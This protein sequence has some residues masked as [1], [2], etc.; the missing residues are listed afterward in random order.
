MAQDLR[1]APTAARNS[2]KIRTRVRLCPACQRTYTYKV[3]PLGGRPPEY[4]DDTCKQWFTANQLLKEVRDEMQ[5]RFAPALWTTTRSEWWHWLNGRS[6]NRGV[7]KD[8]SHTAHSL[9]RRSKDRAR[10]KYRKD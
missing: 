7:T 10:R 9:R 6:W 4:C 8:K 2:L 3:S 5:D 1:E